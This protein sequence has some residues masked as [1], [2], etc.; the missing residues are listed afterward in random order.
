ALQRLLKVSD[1]E[2]TGV[3]EFM[4]SC[5]KT[6]INFCQ[7]SISFRSKVEWMFFKLTIQ[8]SQ[9]RKSIRV[10]SIAQSCGTDGFP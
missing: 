3:M 7:A 8:R 9:P 5:V 2:I 6:R 1:N 4:I 10:A